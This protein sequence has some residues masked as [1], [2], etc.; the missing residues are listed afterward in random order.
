MVEMEAMEVMVQEMEMAEKAVMQDQTMAKGEKVGAVVL[1][2]DVM[3]MMAGVQFN[4]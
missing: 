2:A 3:V 1:M 4:Q